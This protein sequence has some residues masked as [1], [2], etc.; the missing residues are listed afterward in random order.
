MKGRSSYDQVNTIIDELNKCFASKYT[1]L[2]EGRRSK[3]DS[4]RDRCAKYKSQ[5]TKDTKGNFNS[6]AME[7]L[8]LEHP[9]A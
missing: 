5:H 4:I 2:H 7:A 6:Y 3:K 9:L 1:F 8:Q